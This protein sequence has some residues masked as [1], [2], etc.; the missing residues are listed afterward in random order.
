MRK[1]FYYILT[2]QLSKFEQ[3]HVALHDLL[4][5]SHNRHEHHYQADENEGDNDHYDRNN[6]KRSESFSSI[7]V[8]FAIIAIAS[9]T[10]ATS[11]STWRVETPAITC[12]TITLAAHRTTITT[13]LA[14]IA[15]T[16]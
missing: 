9:V 1:V 16:Y 13:T 5:P 15:A 3:L 4:S 11:T 6:K 10:I 8:A 12:R 14:T 2:G 7:A